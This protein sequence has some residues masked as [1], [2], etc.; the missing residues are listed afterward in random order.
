MRMKSS[1]TNRRSSANPTKTSCS[2]TATCPNT[3][4]RERECQDAERLTC[5]SQT[6]KD[7]RARDAHSDYARYRR[8]I[9]C[10]HAQLHFQGRS[11]H[12]WPSN[13]CAPTNLECIRN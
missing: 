4:V 5:I 11:K 8:F 9:L 6:F 10:M 1:P 3:H 13:E 12:H 7:R 2:G